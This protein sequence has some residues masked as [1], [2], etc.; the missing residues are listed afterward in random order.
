MFLIVECKLYSKF[1]DL[2]D[3]CVQR[4]KIS[5]QVSHTH[6]WHS[7]FHSAMQHANSSEEDRILHQLCTKTWSAVPSSGT[8][9]ELHS[10]IP[11][12]LM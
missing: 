1:P 3:L 5:S 6:W 11:E 7:M 8:N 10:R 4:K 2:H 12:V 9:G